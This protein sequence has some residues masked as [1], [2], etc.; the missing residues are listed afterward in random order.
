MVP[1]WAKR[2]LRGTV[3]K[4]NACADC[5]L[6][7]VHVRWIVIY[8]ILLHL[9]WAILLLVDESVAGTPPVS[10][11]TAVVGTPAAVGILLFIASAALVGLLMRS[12]RWGFLLLG[13]Q[14]VVLL[15][16]AM[17]S[18]TAILAHSYADGVPRPWAF[19]AA[20]QFPNILTAILYACAVAEQGRNHG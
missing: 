12:F 2:L 1:D 9:A 5:P 13:P 3:I 6:G 18:I 15:H 7:R 8:A 4:L 14:Q 16:S 17:G 11:L 20:D 10:A 19:I